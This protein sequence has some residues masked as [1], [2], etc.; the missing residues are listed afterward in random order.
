[1]R[2]RRVDTIP[3]LLVELL[4][5]LTVLERI[6]FLG[7]IHIPPVSDLGETIAK[8]CGVKMF[9]DTGTFRCD[10]SKGCSRH[11]GRVLTVEGSAETYETT[12]AACKSFTNSEFNHGDSGEFLKRFVPTLTEPALSWLDAHAGGGNFGDKDVCPLLA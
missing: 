11:Y 9:V 10:A 8:Q 5:A 1:M 2:N 4:V 6:S 7:A 3:T 12:K